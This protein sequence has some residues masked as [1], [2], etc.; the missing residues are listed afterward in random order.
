MGLKLSK[1]ST[2]GKMSVW[3]AVKVLLHEHA[4]MILMVTLTILLVAGGE[5]TMFLQQ[6]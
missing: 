3:F 5:K 2:D 1:A 4:T 6:V